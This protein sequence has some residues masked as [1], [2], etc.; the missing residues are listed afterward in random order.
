MKVL[1]SP[2]ATTPYYGNSWLRFFLLKT[3]LEVGL[4][5]LSLFIR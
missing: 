3:E 5:L 2:Q 4:G 1:A